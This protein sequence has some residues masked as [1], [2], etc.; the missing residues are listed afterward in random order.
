MA[1]WKAKEEQIWKRKKAAEEQQLRDLGMDEGNIKALHT[2]D[3]EEF[4]SERR[5][6]ERRADDSHLTTVPASDN[7][8]LSCAEQLLDY[9]ESP[10]LHGVLLHLDE[11]SVKII[12]LK[13]SG[14]SVQ[15][16]SAQLH[17]TSKAVYRRL[18]RIKEKLKNIIT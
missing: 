11:A 7:E 15:E 17:L 4:K 16:I 2:H 5:Y 12:Y 9:I 6:N 10:D 1:Y 3:W 18:D 14:F 13:M 8:E